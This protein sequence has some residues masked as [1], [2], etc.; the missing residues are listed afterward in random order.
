MT[1]YKQLLHLD[2]F[3]NY[4]RNSN[5]IIMQI[6]TKM[7]LFGF[8]LYV[9]AL[10]TDYFFDGKHKYVAI[11]QKWELGFVNPVCSLLRTYRMNVKH[12]K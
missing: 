6:Y 8:L 12:I 11:S 7:D 10:Y 5:T 9:H 4:L 2:D 1:R 3:I